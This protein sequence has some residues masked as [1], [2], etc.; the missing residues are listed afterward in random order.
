ML[1]IPFLILPAIGFFLLFILF[2]IL[3]AP[4]K[5][6]LKLLIN[7]A[8]GFLAL[9]LINFFGDPIGLALDVNWINA[10]VIGVFGVPGTIVLILINYLL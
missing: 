3:K 9:V 1:Y 7:A 5:L 4:L 8:L 6:A 2:K 10:I